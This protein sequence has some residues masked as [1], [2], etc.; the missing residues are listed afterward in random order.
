MLEYGTQIVAG[1]TPGKGG[2]TRA[3]RR[4][5][6]LRHRRRSGPRDRRE[7]GLHLRPGRR[8][9]PTRSWRRPAPGI[10]TIF[11]I[12]EGIPAL[13]MIPAVAVVQAAGARLIGPELPRRD[14]PG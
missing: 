14:V 7:H 4:G 1:V 10:A 6:G 13:D 9:R 11:C 2:Q 8:A 12:T 3:R 5:P